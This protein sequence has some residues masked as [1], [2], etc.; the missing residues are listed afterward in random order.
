[1]GFS[2]VSFLGFNFF[3]GRLQMVRS[4]IGSIDEVSVIFFT[5]EAGCLE[6]WVFFGM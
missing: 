1:M 6:S 4:H 5:R 3:Q 2:R